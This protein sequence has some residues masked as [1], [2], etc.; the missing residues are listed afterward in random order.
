MAAFN[1]NITITGDCNNTNSGIINL[2]LTGGT[3]PY[4][5]Q[6][7]SPLTQTNVVGSGIPSIV[8]GLSAFTYTARVNDSTLPINEE[9]YINVPISSG[10]CA[11]ILG[12]QD[13]T[14]DFANGSVTGTSTSQ[15]SSTNFY[16][17]DMGNTLI[18]S[19]VTNSSQVVF[20]N[21]DYGSYYMVAQD[22]GGCTGETQSFIIDTSTTF[23]FGLYVVPNSS[24]GGNPIGKITVTGQTG[25]PPFSYLWSNGQ[26][27]STITGL[28]SGNYS[29]AVTDGY[30]CTKS[31]EGSVTNVN[32]IGLGIITA[33][34][35]SCFQNNG[36]INLTITGGTAP[37]YYSASTGNVLISY[38]RTYSLS[39]LTAGDYNFQVTDAAYCQLFAGTTLQTPGGITSV[40][41]SNQNSTCSS[42]NGLIQISVIGGSTPYTYTLISPDSSQ[43]NIN[44]SQTTYIFNGLSTGEYTVAVSDST[45][46]SYMQE[47]TII[48]ENK[49]TISTEV[50]STTCN[51]NNGLIT[52]YSTTGGTMPLDYSV[53]ESYSVLDTNL[54]AVTFNN[55]SAG[56]H[57]V[58]VTDSDGCVQTQIVSIP[59]SQ[60]LDFSLYSTSCGSGNDGQITA[61]ISSGEPPFN[62]NWSDNIPNEPQQIQVS[63][64]TAGTYSLTVV[65]SNGCSLTR[66]TNITCYQNYVS[67][68]SYVMGDEV[69]NISSPT[70]FGMLQ[71]LNEGFYDLTTGNTKCELVSATYTAKVY[72]NPSG[73]VVSQPFFTSTSLVQAPSDNLWYNT[74]KSLLLSIPGVGNVTIDELN[75]QITIETSKN[76]TSLKG[77][78]IVIDLVIVYDIMCLS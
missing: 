68:Q 62:F 56:T 7:Q 45:G 46:C 5:V 64:L 69:F 51:Q 11:S 42:T 78:E 12:V 41:V 61:F 74:V 16:L 20:S 50:T 52:I 66:S 75:N 36:V 55:L 44:T 32:P 57:T 13:T 8:T 49:F 28:T 3:P 77:Q 54:S 39:G 35:P 4:T 27:G 1:Y 76:N 43:T 38:S 58:T 47:I 22:L 10:V 6:W 2:S 14:C 29:V 67:Y 18:Q 26:T 24:C 25:Q 15:Y 70:K 23:D 37:F 60:R 53:D 30:G 17:Y 33:T 71:M 21:I 72:V 31:E 19:A 73:Y 9:F 63:G 34:S 48:A 40:S 65:D 59:F